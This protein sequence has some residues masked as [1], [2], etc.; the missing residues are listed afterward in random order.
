M[1][2]L[3]CHNCGWS[4]DDFWDF[5][6]KWS[7]LFCWRS[8]PFGYNPL[9]LILEDFAEYWKPRYVGFDFYAAKEMGVKLKKGNKIH[10]WT[11][12]RYNL[13]RHIKRLFTQKWW[14]E[15]S[16]KKDYYN[17]VALCPE[18]SANDFDID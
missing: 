14:T 13:K 10:S 3:H 18:C 8:R 7:K 2:Y 5:K 12:L 6:I 9:S 17:R 16:F 4:Q 11:L 1:S 15:K